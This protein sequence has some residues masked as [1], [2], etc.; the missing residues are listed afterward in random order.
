M[1]AFGVAHE[2]TDYPL[3]DLKEAQNRAESEGTTFRLLPPARV[4]Q[5]SS[6][7]QNSPRQDYYYDLL[8]SLA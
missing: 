6:Y 2:T 1:P 8:P 5:A 3:N 7:S 4:G